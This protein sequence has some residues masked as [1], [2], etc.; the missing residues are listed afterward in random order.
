MNYHQSNVFLQDL[1]N[2]F[3]CGSTFLV[4]IPEYLNNPWWSL[5]SSFSAVEDRRRVSFK[6][7]SILCHPLIIVFD[8]GNSFHLSGVIQESSQ[9]CYPESINS[10]LFILSCQL[11]FSYLVGASIKYP[12][13]S[14]WSLSSHVSSLS[15]A[16]S[17]N[18]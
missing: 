17:F 4:F 2:S 3:H 16:S 6:S 1:S 15:Q 18:C 10:G 5:S 13:I 9:F 8:C 12:L 14:S 11:S 7:C